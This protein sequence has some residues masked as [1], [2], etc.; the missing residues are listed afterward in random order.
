MFRPRGGATVP[1]EARGRADRVAG[2]LLAGAVGDALG[3]PVEFATLERIR[4]DHG[5]GGIRDLEKAYDRVGA[6]TDDTQLTLFAAEGLLRARTLREEGGARGAE[7]DGAAAVLRAYRRGLVTQGDDVPSELLGA[8][9]WLMELPELHA[10]WSPGHACLAALRLSGGAAPRDRISE[11][12]ACGG[13]VRAA[14]AGLVE[15]DDPFALGGLV[16]APTHAHPTGL[17]TAG[18]LALLVD[19]LVR[20]VGLDAAIGAARARLTAEPEHAEVLV[21]VDRAVQ[22]VG[23]TEP[24]AEAVEELGRGWVGEEALAIGLYCV[25]AH[26]AELEAAV[27]LAANHSGASDSTAAVT[28]AIAGALL[29]EAAIPVRWLDRLELREAIGQLAADLAVGYRPT[30]EWRRLYPPS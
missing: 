10:R 14:P 24:S 18:F 9:G 3:A 5:P 7:D 19:R 6:I 22:R 15:A 30:A 26:P 25:L 8:R 11:R 23:S 1:T 4:R 21:A 28:G 29:G 13:I 16:A 2:C 12:Q 17:L 20:G 27:V